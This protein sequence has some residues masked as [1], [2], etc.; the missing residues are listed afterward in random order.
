MSL[1]F[2]SPNGPYNGIIQIYEKEGGYNLGD[3]SGNT[4]LLK[5]VTADINLA[6]D[7]LWNLAFQ[8]G[9]TWVFDDS[10]QTDYPFI[11]TNLISGQRDYAFT[12][13]GS[14]NLILDIYRVMIANAAGIF[15]EIYPVDVSTRNNNTTETNSFIDGQNKTGAP[16]RY[17]K[18]GNGILLDLIP[19]YNAAL[20]LKVFINREGSYFLYTDTT[21]KAGVPGNLHRYLAIK[22]A[23]D[24]ARQTNAKNYN[25]LALE[26]ARLEDTIRDTF[27]RRQKD[28]TPKLIPNVEA[29]W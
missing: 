22:P 3:V 26:V 14:G 15:Q 25:L 20:G 5:Q 27:R 6:L 16:F 12:V 1:V 11:Q 29:T 13:D 19:N 4:D 2:N 9:G 18:T 21:K 23:F 17:D 10:N 28:V 7:D 8:A 24:R